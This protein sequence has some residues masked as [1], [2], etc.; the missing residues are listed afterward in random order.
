MR[1]K[2]KLLPMPQ[3]FRFENRWRVKKSSP[4]S[5]EVRDHSPQLTTM[6]SG[7]MKF[8]KNR[9][10]TLKKPTTFKT[11]TCHYVCCRFVVIC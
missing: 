3:A 1:R 11:R 4:K 7:L 8:K 6:L 10:C 9:I 5:G 2:V